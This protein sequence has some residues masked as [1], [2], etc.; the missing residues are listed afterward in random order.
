MI[1]A[2]PRDS[3]LI[4]Q[5]HTLQS[6]YYKFPGGCDVW[7]RS[8]EPGEKEA[9]QNSRLFLQIAHSLYVNSYLQTDLRDK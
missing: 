2:L 3:G 6:G 1:L 8:S 7:P 4:G 5:G 9:G